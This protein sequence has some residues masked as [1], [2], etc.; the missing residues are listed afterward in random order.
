M[1]SS[2]KGITT[3]KITVF[4]RVSYAVMM[5]LVGVLIGVCGITRMLKFQY[6]IDYYSGDVRERIVAGPL[7]L[8]DRLTETAF[9]RYSL[10]VPIGMNPEWHVMCEFP[11][12]GAKSEDR[13]MMRDADLCFAVGVLTALMERMEPHE[14]V[15]TKEE[16]ILLLRQEG[17]EKA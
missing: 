4:K 5:I 14:A 9:C 13:M 10:S 11:L 12:V 7:T 15:K 3:R 16:F 17:Q 2:E 6:V 1:T 8:H